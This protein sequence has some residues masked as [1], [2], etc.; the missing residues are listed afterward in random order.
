MSRY[1]I[2]V[3]LKKTKMT[4]KLEWR[5]YYIIHL[6]SY[7]YF[8]TGLSLKKS[9]RRKNKKKYRTGGMEQKKHTV[10]TGQNGGVDGPLTPALCVPDRLLLC[11]TQK[12]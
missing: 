2:I 7:F 11:A 1:I 3:Y 5:E 4:Y 8:H 10:G 12:K 9:I 6:T